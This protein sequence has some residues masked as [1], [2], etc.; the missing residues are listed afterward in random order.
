MQSAVTSLTVGA[1]PG[2]ISEIVPLLNRQLSYIPKPQP[3]LWHA[4]AAETKESG[5]L[6]KLSLLRMWSSDLM[7]GWNFF[8]CLSCLG[9]GKKED[10]AICPLYTHF[11][12]PSGSKSWAVWPISRGMS[13]ASKSKLAMTLKHFSHRLPAAKLF[14]QFILLPS[15]YIFIFLSL[16]NRLCRECFF[17]CY[18]TED[19]QI[20][21]SLYCITNITPF[22]NLDTI[23]FYYFSIYIMRILDYFPL[24]RGLWVCLILALESVVTSC[25]SRMNWEILDC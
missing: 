16:Y 24:S 19:R 13:W 14:F 5:F 3:S 6:V 4:I 8:W 17:G 10:K 18:C 23:L 21:V 9:E 20:T 25:K 7:T 15:A 22:L 12:L 1:V 11:L 2:G